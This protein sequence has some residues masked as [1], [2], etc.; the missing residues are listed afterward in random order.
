[1][2]PCVSQMLQGN[3]EIVS[4]ACPAIE[5]DKGG[6]GPTDFFST[7]KC[8]AMKVAAILPDKKGT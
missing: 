2:D 4:S 5:S 1:M 6:P 7:Q 8:S 3:Q